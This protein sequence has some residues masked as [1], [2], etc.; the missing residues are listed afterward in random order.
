M[1]NLYIEG[2]DTQRDLLEIA[3]QLHIS[4]TARDVTVTD[5]LDRTLTF[6]TDGKKQKHQLGAATFDAKTYWDAGQ[7]KYDIEGPD[8][9]KMNETVFLSPEG[10]R[11]F[12]LIRLGERAK[13]APAI[14]VNRVYD[15]VK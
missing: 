15:R 11:L 3:P 6:T 1:A 10:D 2:R 12:M 7:F 9:L 4:I 14:G 13:D 5:D 8:G